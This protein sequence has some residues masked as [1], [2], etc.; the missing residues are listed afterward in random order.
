MY[1]ER[2]SKIE[3]K[4]RAAEDA[5]LCVEGSQMS[6]S[7]ELQASW[8]KVPATDVASKRQMPIQVGMEKTTHFN[9]QRSNDA[10]LEMAIVDFF[11]CENVPNRVVES[12]QFKQMLNQ[13]R[14]VGK[15]FRFPSRKKLEVSKIYFLFYSKNHC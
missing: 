2:E 9:I 1:L 10:N 8:S 14:L 12:T 13:A 15:G 5:S 11:H 4:K 3:S 6:A 7:M